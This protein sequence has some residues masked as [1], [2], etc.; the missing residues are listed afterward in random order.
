M[1]KRA[2]LLFAMLIAAVLVTIQSCTSQTGDAPIVS[3][4][5]PSSI[6]MRNQDIRIN[7]TKLAK[8]IHER[9]NRARL[10]RGLPTFRWDDALGRIARAH[11]RDM[12]ARNYFSHTS[13]EGHGY[14]YRY[15]KNNYACGITV[16]GVT[17]NGAENIFQFSLNGLAADAGKEQKNERYVWETIAAST[18]QGWLDSSEDRKNI[19]SLHWQREAVGIFI[20]PDNRVYITVNFC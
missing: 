6:P 5:T 11:S 14:S 10:T 3:S 20:G 1:S 17:R 19:L 9:V 2:Q 8:Y 16:N 4:G 13:P 7:S 15:I 18:I 12:A